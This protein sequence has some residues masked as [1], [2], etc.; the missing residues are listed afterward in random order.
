MAVL[1]SKH[2]PILLV[3]CNA[4]LIASFALAETSTHSTLSQTSSEVASPATVP[5][6]HTKTT[7]SRKH[8]LPAEATDIPSHTIQHHDTS[9]IS[10]DSTSTSANNG[11][12]GAYPT[13]ASSAVVVSSQ[14]PGAASI[15]VSTQSTTTSIL[16]PESDNEGEHEIMGSAGP[17]KRE[18]EGIQRALDWLKE[19]RAPDYGWG[20]D[21]HMVIL[22][23]EVIRENFSLIL[24]F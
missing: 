11:G 10:S 9:V 14:P 21:T 24:T 7:Q 5:A 22:A 15:T 4:L 3:I 2:H 23:K 8:Y 12:N 6:V 18:L 1:N 20:N 16:L 17:D 19:K 13:S